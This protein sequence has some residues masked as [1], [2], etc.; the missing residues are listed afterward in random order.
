MYM[1]ILTYVLLSIT[2]GIFIL[3]RVPYSNHVQC[4]VIKLTYYV[5][6]IQ[7]FTTDTLIGSL[8]YYIQI[9]KNML[10]PCVP[11]F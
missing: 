4:I 2:I 5:Q 1:V 3:L 10:Q 11:D 6:D 7:P 9:L 8:Y